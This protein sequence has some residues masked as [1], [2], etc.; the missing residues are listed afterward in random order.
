M[1]RLYRIHRLEFL[2]VRVW[3]RRETKKMSARNFVVP[4]TFA[5]LGACAQPQPAKTP[6]IGNPKAMAAA[7]AAMGVEG[8]DNANHPGKAVYDR[9][10]AACHNNPEATRSPSLDTLKSMR[11]QTISYALTQGKM[12]VQASAL[13]AQERSDVIDFLVGR[14]VT[15]DDWVAKAMC[16]ASRGKMDLSATPTVTGFGFDQKNHRHLSAE[17]AGL[18]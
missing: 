9:V 5:F 3:V 17:Q 8:A 7:Q 18:R 16:P 6:S 12:Q 2:F 1:R 13:S 4:V 15:R 10:C 11:Y 14:E